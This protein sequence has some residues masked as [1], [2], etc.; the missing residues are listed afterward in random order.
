[1]W[2]AKQKG[3]AAPERAVLG[4]VTLAGDPAGAY[5]EGERRGVAVYAP[6]GYHWA[7]QQGDEI[8]VL[9]AGERPCAVGVPCGDEALTLLPGEVAITAG[10]SVIRLKPGGA[11]D[12]TGTVRVNGEVV[13]AAY[14]PPEEGGKA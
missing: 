2:L 14:T 10:V 1:M 3:R 7:P 5:L 13:G 6:R 8:L 4:P 11:I 12:I 9:K